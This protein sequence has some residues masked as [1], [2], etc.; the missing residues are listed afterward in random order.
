M[1]A[2]TWQATGAV[3]AASGGIAPN[4]PAH[5][6]GD[7][8]LLLVCQGTVSPGI[9]TT[10]NGFSLITLTSTAGQSTGAAWWCRATS[11]SMSAPAVADSGDGNA[12]C[13]ITFR[14]CVGSGVPWD[15]YNTANQT[16]TSSASINSISTTLS[17]LL[18]V[19]QTIAS[20]PVNDTTP[21]IGTNAVTNS[22]CTNVTVQLD[23][24][25]GLNN[26][27]DCLAIITSNPINIG[28][29][30]PTTWALNIS[31]R[32][33]GHIMIALKSP[34]SAITSGNFFQFF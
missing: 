33:L 10:A 34:T 5:Q 32:A 12:G 25:S 8:G 27:G 9:L 7:I 18:L 13:I 15:L 2:P 22:A 3:A 30:G 24:A 26:N 4:W 23:S 29:T 28:T 21:L 6:T 1:A 14:G 11:G 17:D 20:H 31:A 16:S 19:T